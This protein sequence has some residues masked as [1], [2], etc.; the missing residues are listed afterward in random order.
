MPKQFL[1]NPDGSIPLN[2]NI[3]LL[4]AESIPLVMPTPMPRES[5]MVAVEQDPQ[6][7]ADGVWRQVWALELAPEPEPQPEQPI[8]ALASLTDEQKQSLLAMLQNTI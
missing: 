6:Q 3:E 8:D 1:L 2:A 5:G 4:Q 7:D